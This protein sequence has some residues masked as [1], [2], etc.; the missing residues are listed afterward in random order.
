MLEVA[1]RWCHVEVPRPSFA[2]IGGFLLADPYCHTVINNCCTL[3]YKGNVDVAMSM[4]HR[5]QAT[6]SLKRRNDQPDASTVDRH[7]T[8]ALIS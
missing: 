8:V 1:R 3:L 5:F 6:M 2:Q 4:Y 7:L